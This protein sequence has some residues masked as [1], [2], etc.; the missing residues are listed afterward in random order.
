M[1]TSYKT[2]TIWVPWDAL[3]ANHALPPPGTVATR[4]ATISGTAESADA[5]EAQRRAEERFADLAKL[6]DQ[7]LA[8]D[9]RRCQTELTP[10]RPTHCECGRVIYKPKPGTTCK[11]FNNGR[12]WGT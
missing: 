5:V 10:G 3:E 8:S 12:P 4:F 11:T 6:W 2:V 1:D 9:G 7:E